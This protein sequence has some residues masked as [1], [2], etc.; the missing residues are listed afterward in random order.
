MVR[1]EVSAKVVQRSVAKCMEYF[2]NKVSNV[3]TRHTDHMKLLLIW[4]FVLLYS[5]KNFGS[6]FINVNMWLY[7]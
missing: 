5:L 6:I 7:V 3:S 4:L 1:N 2:S